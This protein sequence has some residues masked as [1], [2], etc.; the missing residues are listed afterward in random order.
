MRRGTDILLRISDRA[1]WFSIFFSSATY[2]L[3]DSGS[4]MKSEMPLKG[5][6]CFNAMIGNMNLI[7]GAQEGYKD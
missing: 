2:F 3:C 5:D 4:S 6:N 1:R 7:S